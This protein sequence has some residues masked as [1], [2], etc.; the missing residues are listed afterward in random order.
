MNP[1][2]REARLKPGGGRASEML[3][4]RGGAK[5]PRAEARVWV[6]I[7]DQPLKRSRTLKKECGCILAAKVPKSAAPAVGRAVACGSLA[8][9]KWNGAVSTRE[10]ASFLREIAQESHGVSGNSF[11]SPDGPDSLGAFALYAD[12]FCIN[13]GG[14]GDCLSHSIKERAE[15]RFLGDNDRV[16]VLDFFSISANKGSD[17]GQ[18]LSA[19]FVLEGVVCAGEMKPD[20]PEGSGAEE[21][22][23]Y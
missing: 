22:I 3:C 13:V 2:D 8:L 23:A 5:A 19:G 21:S 10:G 17:G 9:E 7:R 4:A 6:G 14:G 11:S 12:L 16:N 20:I 18:E 15:P 1:L